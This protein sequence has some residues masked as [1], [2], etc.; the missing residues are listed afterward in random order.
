MPLKILWNAIVDANA[1]GLVRCVRRIVGNDHDTE[2]VVQQVFLEAWR[3]PNHDSVENW[4]AFLRR[5]AHR[6]AIDHLRKRVRAKKSSLSAAEHRASAEDSPDASLA[7]SELATAL[8]QAITQLTPSEATVFTM[9]YFDELDRTEISEALD[10]SVNAVTVSLH[11]AR[12]RL[13][14][15]LGSQT[16]RSKTNER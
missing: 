6:R 7:A 15:L 2:D 8:R 13:K 10:V 14:E 3:M 9:T 1:A 11:K 16:T 12:K 4:P 5:M